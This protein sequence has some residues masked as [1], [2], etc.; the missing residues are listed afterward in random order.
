MIEKAA[1]AAHGA[2]SDVG[3]TYT[4]HG[5]VW[6]DVSVAQV[7]AVLA[8]IREP[9]EAMIDAGFNAQPL[10]PMRASMDRYAAAWRAMVDAIL[11]EEGDVG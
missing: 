11:K 10:W 3:V 7:R 9:S 1:Q 2:N 4:D 5:A 8:A 6:T